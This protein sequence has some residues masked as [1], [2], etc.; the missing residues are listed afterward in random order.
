[1]TQ[2]LIGEAGNNPPYVAARRIY[3]FRRWRDAHC[4]GPYFGEPAWDMLLQLFIGE[5]ADG[6]RDAARNPLILFP[7][8][9]KRD[10]ATLVHDDI[11]RAVNDTGSPS[12][13]GFQLAPKGRDFMERIF[14]RDVLALLDK[15]C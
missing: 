6:D 10:I 4:P 14:H 12:G 1:M 9:W 7:N 13:W 2:N 11:I 15:P 8:L 5:Q 3:E